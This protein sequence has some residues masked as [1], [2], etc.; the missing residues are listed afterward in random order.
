MY[1]YTDDIRIYELRTWLI[2]IVKINF[3]PFLLKIFVMNWD[4]GNIK[5]NLKTIYY[6]LYLVIMNF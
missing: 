6:Q 2:A 1:A 4:I 5:L 3:E